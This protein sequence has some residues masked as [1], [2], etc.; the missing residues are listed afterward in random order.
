MCLFNQNFV[1]KKTRDLIKELMYSSD[2]LEFFKSLPEEKKGFLLL[3]LSKKF[4]KSILEDLEDSEILLF[5]KFL[6]LDKAADILI[7]VEE[8][9]RKRI[10]KKLESGVKEKL[11]LL[12]KFN[13]ESAAGLM[14]LDYIEIDE[15]S[16]VN[17]VIKAVEVHERETGKSPCILVLNDGFLVGELLFHKLVR[18][19]PREKIK[20]HIKTI[21]KVSYN[22]N[23]NE[24]PKLFKNN[25]HDKIVVV[26]EDQSVL[27]IVYAYDILKILEETESIRSFA[28]VSKEEHVY[29]GF[30]DKVKSRYKWLIL[31][32]ATAFLAASVVGLFED[33]IA[34]FTLL[35][36]YMPVVAGMGGN[37]GTQTLAVFIRGIALKEVALDKRAIKAIYNEMMTGA[38]TGT[39][40]GLLAAFIAVVW[41][42]S[43]LLGFV[44]GVAMVLN[45]IIAG[46]FG[47]IIPLIM[48]KLGKDPATSA[49]IFITTATDV[50]GFFVFLGLASLVL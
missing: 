25:S 40:T 2:K 46:F 20:H 19:K 10:L 48:K 16:N 6:D 34:T 49:T 7:N 14:T 35:A 11:K 3:K 26:D 5:I 4:Q 15:G 41:N 50:L 42:K 32:L 9:K 30:Q 17:Q 45:L 22:V 18:L 47:A 13:P 24:L 33:T 39:I 28:G 38:V 29:D 8:V 37:A 1:N 12:L 43:P 36:I 31:N 23:A 21:P 27:G 44:I